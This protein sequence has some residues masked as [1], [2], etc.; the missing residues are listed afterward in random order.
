MPVQPAAN[1]ARNASCSA[2][3]RKTGRPCLS[4]T[5]TCTGNHDFSSARG[6]CFMPAF[7]PFGLRPAPGRRPPRPGRNGSSSLFGVFLR[8]VFF[9]T[10]VITL[11]SRSLPPHHAM[12]A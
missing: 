11:T 10:F 5:V 6:R 1:A 4:L 9:V 8:D 7:V 3:L 2:F 12:R